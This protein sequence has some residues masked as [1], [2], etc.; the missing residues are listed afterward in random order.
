MT[1][2]V[3]VNSCPRMEGF[4]EEVRLVVVEARLTE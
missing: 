2:A 1:T 3:R 4:G